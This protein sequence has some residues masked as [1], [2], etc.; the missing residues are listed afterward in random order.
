[1]P[2]KG[3]TERLLVMCLGLWTCPLGVIVE[4]TDPHDSGLL[5]DQEFWLGSLVRKE[6]KTD[7]NTSTRKDRRWR[8]ALSSETPEPNYSSLN[9]NSQSAAGTA[10]RGLVLHALCLGYYRA[11]CRLEEEAE[12]EVGLLQTD[13]QRIRVKPDTA[14]FNIP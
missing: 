12:D 10:T 4:T 2:H 11:P 6:K 14:T 9:R 3:I 1:M 8:P 13:L 7:K 5:S